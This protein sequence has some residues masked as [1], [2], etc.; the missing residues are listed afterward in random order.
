M[1]VAVGVIA[2]PAPGDPVGETAPVDDVAPAG[3]AEPLGVPGVA[4]EQPPTAI[5]AAQTA[6]RRPGSR[7][8]RRGRA[9]QR[10][11][12]ARAEE[13]PVG[14]RTGPPYEVILVP[15]GRD[16]G[17]AA[18][19]CAPWP[20][21]G[22]H[23]PAA[24]GADSAG[25]AG[26]P[27]YAC[28]VDSPDP[29][30]SS[31]R[32]AV[33]AAPSDIPLRRHLAALLAEQGQLEEAVQHAAAALHAGPADELSR[34]LMRQLLGV[35]TAAPAPPV[36]AGDDRAVRAERPD[37]GAASMAGRAKARSTATL[38]SG[39]TMSPRPPTAAARHPV[40]RTY[41]NDGMERAGRGPAAPTPTV[42]AP[43]AKVWGPV[44]EAADDADLGPAAAIVQAQ[45]ATRVRDRF[46]S[47]DPEPV[48]PEPVGLAYD[49]P[50][51]DGLAYDGLAY[52]DLARDGLSDPFGSTEPLH[53]ADDPAARPAPDRP[54]DGRSPRL[55]EEPEEFVPD[56]RWML[57]RPGDTRSGATGSDATGSGTESH[58]GSDTGSAAGAERGPQPEPEPEGGGLAW[59]VEQVHVTLADVGGMGTA[60]ER[61]EAV[62][63]APVRYPELRRLYRQSLT[64]GVLLYGPPGC[65][66]TFL[67]R[68]VAGELGARFV[69]VRVRDIVEPAA[70]AD[71]GDLDKVLDAAHEQAPVVVLLE[72]IDVLSRRRD[73]NL[74]AARAVDRIVHELDRGGL[75][76]A[77]VYLLATTCA[78]WDVHDELRRDGRLSRSL[79]VMPPDQRAREVILRQ[80]LTRVGRAGSGD[81]PVDIPLTELSLLTEGY[82]CTDL[83]W[84][85]TLGASAAAKMGLPLSEARLRT[86]VPRIP[87]STETWMREA[88]KAARD[89]PGDSLYTGLRE[90]LRAR[91]RL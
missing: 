27:D 19:V 78:P 67:A 41:A 88:A 75:A 26:R 70:D 34:D 18:A 66:K 15:L 64:G 2:G 54:L 14:L 37:Q 69:D 21:A 35:P 77:G 51:Y 29:L 33:Q 74:H 53:A 42:P 13:G 22:R 45:E 62:M 9:V 63:L 55:P 52:G 25:P 7:A 90:Y 46:A 11:W 23:R 8:A 89:N 60:K 91:R 59:D 72:D 65:G 39:R 68:A 50:A 58:L 32:Q 43:V 47:V 24:V 71:S 48:G 31:M 84:L 1:T 6:A 57:G 28:V 76:D 86:I 38:P 3:P 79:L 10:P 4:A 12:A 83:E 80:E 16:R 20:G 36:E 40:A 87:P 61:L 85:C 30:V 5:A 44:P 56:A 49:G 82:S 73:T 17:L 81:T